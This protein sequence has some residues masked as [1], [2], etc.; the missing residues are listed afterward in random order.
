MVSLDTYALPEVIRAMTATSDHVALER[1]TRIARHATERG[2]VVA[3]D[4]DATQVRRAVADWQ[5]WWF[6][7]ATD[8]VELDGADRAIAVVTETR[9]GKWLRRAASGSS[10]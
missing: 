1:L 4:S 8:Y 5:E 9:Y 10:A 3:E 2:T 7:H 6:V